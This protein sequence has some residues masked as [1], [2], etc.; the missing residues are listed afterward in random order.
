VP[1][2][3]RKEKEMEVWVL[4]RPVFLE[5]SLGLIHIGSCRMVMLWK[6]RL[7]DISDRMSEEEGRDP[8]SAWGMGTRLISMQV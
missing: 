8:S 3:S 2:V 4:G 7:A 1:S 6:A 5:V